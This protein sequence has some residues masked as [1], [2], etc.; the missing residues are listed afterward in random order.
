MMIGL[1][2]LLKDNTISNDWTALSMMEAL[3]QAV[4][5]PLLTVAND[6]SFFAT[7]ATDSITD[8]SSTINLPG[9]NSPCLNVFGMNGSWVQDWNY[10]TT[11]GQYRQPLVAPN[12]PYVKRKLDKFRPTNDNQDYAP[13]RWETSWKWV[14]NNDD[15]TSSSCP[16]IDHTM[17]EAK[18][19]NLFRSLGGVGRVL[20]FGDSLTESMFK[21]FV[22]LL[23]PASGGQ[24]DQ[25]VQASAFSKHDPQGT[26]L[27]AKIRCRRPRLRSTATGANTTT[28]ANANST[29]TVVVDEIPIVMMR[30]HGGQAFFHSNRSD[31]VFDNFTRDFVSFSPNNRTLAIFNLGVHYH[32]LEHYQED[33]EKLLFVLDELQRPQD[34]YFFRTSVP[35][36]VDCQPRKPRSFNYTK[37]SRIVPLATFEDYAAT[38]MY[39]WNEMFDYNMHAKQVIENRRKKRNN[40]VNENSSNIT[41]QGFVAKV[42]ILDVLNMTI[43][44]HDGHIGGQDCLHYFLPGPP[45][46]W[47]H[48]LYTVLVELAGRPPLSSLQAA[49]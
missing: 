31:F 35:G 16:Q 13:F 20:F 43:L 33:L 41:S 30:D 32:V 12:S 28:N 14:A 5:T 17:T 44:R 48:L 8:S 10:S 25:K 39:N 23:H 40:S 15:S 22:N 49:K 29:T 19:C 1:Q 46:W 9:E 36:H 27:F 4:S 6:S 38:T 42:H 18:I 37:G 7:T 34:L 2:L 47:N 45:D 21:S 11:Y 24:Y 26:P 3:E